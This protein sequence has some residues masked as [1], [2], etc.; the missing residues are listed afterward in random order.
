MSESI[1][2][3]SIQVILPELA[4]Q[5]IQLGCDGLSEQQIQQQ[6]QQQLQNSSF[7]E[8]PKHHQATFVSLHQK[9]KLR[10]CIGSLEAW[11]PLSDDVIGN[12]YAAAF[13]D[14]R[15]APVTAHELES[16]DLE[17]SLLSPATALTIASEQDL[18]SQ[19]Q[20]GVDGLI[21][22]DGKGHRAT[23]LPQVWEQLPQPE[24][25]LLRLKRKAGLKGDS[26]PDGMQCFRYHCTIF[27]HP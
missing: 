12:A 19:L 11:R 16:L 23:F 24:N 3:D 8:E 1:Q 7:P 25:F 22:D 26:W 15:F 18:L 27:R 21:I 5:T 9:G 4:K 17:V 10:G 20:P 6:L 14:H 2:K 13:R